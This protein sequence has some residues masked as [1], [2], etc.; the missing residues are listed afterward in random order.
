MEYIEKNLIKFNF[1]NIDKFY[2]YERNTVP[3]EIVIELMGINGVN[4]K[5]EEF[6]ISMVLM[7]VF[8]IFFLLLRNFLSGSQL[9]QLLKSNYNEFWYK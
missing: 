1:S 2:Y 3:V 6:D 5:D 8:M 9:L 7:K 4:I